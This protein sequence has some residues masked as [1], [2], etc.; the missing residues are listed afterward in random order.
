MTTF[1]VVQRKL[2]AEWS[3]NYGSFT[4][5]F[6]QYLL[7]TYYVQEGIPGTGNPAPN[8]TASPME[9]TF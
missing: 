9:L 6:S 1:P 4:Q 2:E 5:L 7:S 8:K 3:F